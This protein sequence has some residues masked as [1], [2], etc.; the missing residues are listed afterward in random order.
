[1]IKLR[2][3]ELRKLIEQNSQQQNQVIEKIQ[4][5][6]AIKVPMDNKELYIQEF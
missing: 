5:T 3:S 4:K 1:M 2:Y 6:P